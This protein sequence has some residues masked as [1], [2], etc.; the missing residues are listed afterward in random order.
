VPNS[1][2]TG[3]DGNLWIAGNSGTYLQP[4]AALF[5]VLPNGTI[6]AVDVGPGDPANLNT[7]SQSAGVASGPDG[8]LWATVNLFPESGGARSGEIVRVRPA[9]GSFATS[10][11]TSAVG[12][13]TTGSDS[14]L[15]FLETGGI[16]KMTTSLAFNVYSINAITDPTAALITGPFGDLYTPQGSNI[17]R[18]NTAGQL[19]QSYA[20]ATSARFLCLGPDGAIWFVGSNA[21][22]GRLAP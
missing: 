13:I 17:L 2:V 16:G 10:A 14:S 19:V 22:I 15:W 5:R 9:D 12:A 4:K 7:L 21:E 6:T 8:N 11:L 18:I 3:P 20:I 1:I